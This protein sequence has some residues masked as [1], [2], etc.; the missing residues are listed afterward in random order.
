MAPFE[1]LLLR[2][3]GINL[4]GANGTLWYLSAMLVTLPLVLYISQKIQSVF[5]NYLVWVLPLFLYGIVLHQIGTVRTT[6]WLLSNIRAAAGLLLGGSLYYI[7]GYLRKVRI[8]GFARTLLSLIEV[9]SF[10]MAI[11]YTMFRSLSKT[12]Y[13]VFFILI[14]FFSLY[15]TLSGLSW[16]GKIQ[17]AFPSFL[18]RISLPVYCFQMPVIH[19]VR[20]WMDDMSMGWQLLA[21][22][23]G[24]FLLACMMEGFI[25]RIF[26]PICHCG[27]KWVKE[28]AKV[29]V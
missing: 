11:R 2:N 27:V 29:D 16:T 15:I 8:S 23:V 10:L 28:K 21:V 19:G 7:T 20:Y 22:T 5:Q 13:D 12:Y 18:G 4:A 6:D 26:R 3:T 17:G 25:V 14:L 1:A 9:G 24:T